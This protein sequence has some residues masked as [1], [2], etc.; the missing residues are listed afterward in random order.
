MDWHTE[1]HDRV[2]WGKRNVVF[3]QMYLLLKD[4][5]VVDVNVM[6]IDIM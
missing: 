5:G 6:K 1:S 2:T 4:T 3:V